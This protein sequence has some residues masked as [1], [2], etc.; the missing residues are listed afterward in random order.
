MDVN[1]SVRHFTFSRD[2]QADLH[3][4]SKLNSNRH[5]MRPSESFTQRRELSHYQLNLLFPWKLFFDS[6][7]APIL[8]SNFTACGPEGG[9]AFGS[10]GPFLPPRI[11]QGHHGARSSLDVACTPPSAAIE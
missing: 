7:W 4:I 5:K 10:S 1:L 6:A 2:P 11:A 3:L 9:G 8:A